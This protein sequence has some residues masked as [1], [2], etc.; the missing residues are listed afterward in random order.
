MQKISQFILILMLVTGCEVQN[1]DSQKGVL[2][3]KI[4]T[5][6]T[7]GVELETTNVELDPYTLNKLNALLKKRSETSDHEKGA[8]IDVLSKAFLG[9]PY[10]ANMLHGSEKIPEKLIID[11]RGLDCFTYLD[12]VEALRKSTSPK[13][14]VNNV[15]R[16]R[17]I[18][19]NV[20]FLDRKHFF[21][22][23][24]YREYKLATDITAEIS[25]HAVSIEKYLNKK[26]DDGA[27]L[28]GLPVVKR[29]IT[30][31]PSNFINEEVI[32]RLKSGDFIGIYTK[33]AGLDVTH[34]G[35]FIMTEKGPM[36]RNASSRKENEK[37]VDSPF[38][39]YVAKTP[40]II[41]LRAL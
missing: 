8:L 24:A 25:P 3:N 29:T 7:T 6:Q 16:T 27:Y 14:F 26:A 34:V 15:I 31:I 20:H 37:V 19:G 5:Q 1:S 4:E 17:Y 11:F 2:E 23:W 35:F 22:D 9:T 30:Y 12:Y 28:P 38:M 33:L 40:G 21:T 10:K 13:E 39:D 18:K 32:S 36:L 41:V